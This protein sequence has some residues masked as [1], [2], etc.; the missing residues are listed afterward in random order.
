MGAN[1]FDSS[2]DITGADLESVTVTGTGAF[3]LNGNTLTGNSSALIDNVTLDASGVSGIVTMAVDGTA[4]GVEV[5]TGASADAMQWVP[6]R[7]PVILL[8]SLQMQVMTQSLAAATGFTYDGGTGVDTLTI[9]AGVDLSAQTFTLTSVEQ[10]NL[11]GGGATQTVA[12]SYLTGKTFI[13]AESGAGTA[14]LTVSMDQTAVDLSN[15]GFATSFASG[16]DSITID[17]SGVGLGSTITGSAADDTITG[18]GAADS[19]DGGAAADTIISSA[20]SDTIT[21]ELAQIHS[22]LIQFQ[23]ALT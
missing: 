10:I 8:R 9:N 12:A 2:A 17:A 19:I 18:S 4:A 5:V 3:D 6:L 20:G 21:V 11:V 7:L 22:D 14:V 1:G 23:T 15:L 16:T 13:V